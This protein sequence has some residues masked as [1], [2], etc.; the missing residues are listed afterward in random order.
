M[1]ILTTVLMA[2]T[3]TGI[4]PDD[5]FLSAR[6]IYPA[7]QAEVMNTW[8]G[9]RAVFE[10]PADKQIVLRM[11]GSSLYRVYVNG[12]FVQQGPARAAHEY[13]R[14]DLLDITGHL[15][16]GA[17]I[18]AVEVAGYNVDSYYLLNQPAFLQ[19][20]VVADEKVLAST[21][22]EG[23][24]FEAFM[25]PERV[26]KVQRYSTQR[27]FTESYRFEPGYADWRTQVETDRPTVKCETLPGRKLLP[28]GLPLSQFHCRQ[29]SRLLSTA[30]FKTGQPYNEQ[31]LNTWLK[32]GL[33]RGGYPVDEF[34]ARPAADMFAIATEKI[35]PVNKPID[36][37]DAWTIAPG[38]FNIYDYG[39][40]LTGMPGMTVD[41]RSAT[42]LF[43]I[44][45]ERLT[46][47]DVDWRRG[48]IN[49]IE[50]KLAPGQYDLEAF[51]PYTYRYLKL[52]V[53]EGDCTVRNIYLREVA[54]PDV[55][56]ARFAA[57]DARLN[58]L[59]DAG[60]ETYRQNAVDIFMDCPS[61]ERA[62]WLCDS[63]F[64]AR[65]ALMISGR[66]RIERNFIQNYMLYDGQE[67][68]PAGMLPMCYPSEHRPD[69]FIPN[70]AMW[71]VLE[72]G[73]YAQR[74]GDQKLV[75]ELRPKVAALL[76]YFEGFENDEWGL[77]ENLESWVFI[78]WSRANDFVQDVNFPSNMLYAQCLE[79]AGRLYD[80]DAW[81]AKAA[82]VRR[83]VIDKSFNGEFFVDNAV[84]TEG[85]LVVTDNTTET[86]QYYAFFCDVVTPR[87]HPDLWK[88]MVEVFGPQRDVEKTYPGVYPANMLNGIML[89]LDLLSRY[90]HPRRAKDEAIEYNLYMAN[91]TGTLW[92]N[93]TDF[94]SCN[95]GFASHVVK[96]LYRDVLGLHGYDPQRRHVRLRFADLGMD[97]CQGAVP[98]P[99]GL[100]QLRW[101]MNDGGL[102]YRLDLPAGWTFTLDDTP[103][104]TVE[105]LLGE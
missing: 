63:F 36:V 50:Y 52:M 18:V 55:W 82:R 74:S 72:L 105:T 97:W 39:T 66:T 76:E 98:T 89:R 26:R 13:Y 7:G 85:K 59:F 69:S 94:A 3:L 100:I 95:H 88:K 46:G 32:L 40:N 19:A 81:L 104:L 86:C 43:V 1:F 8:A 44:F 48:W 14:V 37:D 99:D 79:T 91:K 5:R 75:A 2:L 41:C 22:G 29:P 20:E 17:N 16:K 54:N 28:R 42:R 60:R 11:T 84:R 71:F 51:E 70:W 64:T 34:E 4:Q 61:R 25:L 15:N 6:P 67:K 78:E 56:Q 23:V 12:A 73:E 47:D 101:E 80:N 92:E 87:S 31:E 62:G 33:K 38:K 93:V 96:L 58:R 35:T 49:L 9:F 27:T 21:G 77:L 68:I 65:V 102:R 30:T 103:G 90:G 53:L 57:S 83:T 45:D 24:A 10:P